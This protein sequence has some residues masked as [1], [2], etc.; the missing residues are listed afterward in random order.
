ME[1]RP[2][3]PEGG[4]IVDGHRRVAAIRRA[5]A[6]GKDLTDPKDGK[7]WIRIRQFEG[8]DV[9]RVIRI[10]TSNSNKKLP[11]MHIAFVYSQ[12]VAFQ[13]TPQ[14]IADR[15]KVSKTSV[16][17]YLTL[18]NANHDVQ[19][20]V[21]DGE[22]TKTAAVE[23]VRELGEAAGPAL[24]A[25]LKVAKER[26]KAKISASDIKAK[27]AVSKRDLQVAE[28]VRTAI[29]AIYWADNVEDFSDKLRALNLSE[30]IAAGNKTA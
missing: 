4:Y 18:G 6:A 5:V 23:S 9:E 22:V 10:I 2:R 24:K 26:G 17:S 11:P 25:A 13:W 8:N 30:V 27:P 20:L 3:E 16:E 7:L 21:G 15:F 12:L 14:M 28:T 29:L 19:K 1:V